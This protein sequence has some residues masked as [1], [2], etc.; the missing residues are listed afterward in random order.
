MSV[1][2]ATTT[3]DFVAGRRK[4]FQAGCACWV[5]GSVFCVAVSWLAGW[6]AAETGA[7]KRAVVFF[8]SFSRAAGWT[9]GGAFCV[10][11]SWLDTGRSALRSG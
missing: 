11:A 4:L 7:L 3:Y 6:L 10:A 1:L 5:S 9:P 2:V 8:F